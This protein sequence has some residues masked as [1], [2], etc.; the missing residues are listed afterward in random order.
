MRWK[1][2]QIGGLNIVLACYRHHEMGRPSSLKK[3]IP[4]HKLDNSF[5][6]RSDTKPCWVEFMLGDRDPP[7]AKKGRGWWIIPI[8]WRQSQ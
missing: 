7:E 2:P 1:T 3:Y 6:N 5:M 4:R 8:V